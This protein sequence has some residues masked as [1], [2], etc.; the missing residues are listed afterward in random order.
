MSDGEQRVESFK[1]WSEQKMKDQA[2]YVMKT[3]KKDEVNKD[4]KQ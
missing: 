2:K 1:E 4:V 3:D